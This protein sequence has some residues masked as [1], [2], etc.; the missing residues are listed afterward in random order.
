[1]P[2]LKHS[3]VPVTKHSPSNA[4]Q[5][6]HIELTLSHNPIAKDPALHG[7]SSNGSHAPK[8]TGK[9]LFA[10]YDRIFEHKSQYSQSSTLLEEYTVVTDLEEDIYSLLLLSLVYKSNSPHIKH[11][12]NPLFNRH[13]WAIIATSFFTGFFSLMISATILF[14]FWTN[15]P[16]IGENAHCTTLGLFSRTIALLLLMFMIGKL[17]SLV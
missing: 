1:M 10:K 6:K 15:P 14:D 12:E 16:D 13:H 7:S 3:P 4:T 17:F 5:G 9:D 8:T 2:S 11:I